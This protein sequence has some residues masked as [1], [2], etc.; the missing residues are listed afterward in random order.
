[1][2]FLRKLNTITCTIDLS[3]LQSHLIETLTKLIE[4]M[5]EWN[6]SFFH[7]LVV[8]IDLIVMLSHIRK[9]NEI[10]NEVHILSKK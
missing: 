9:G 5:E 1:M 4:L 6:N 2:R 10:E 8:Q 3:A 7:K